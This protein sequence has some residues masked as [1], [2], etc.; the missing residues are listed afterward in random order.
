MRNVFRTSLALYLLISLGSTFANEVNTGADNAMQAGFTEIER[1]LIIKYMGGQTDKPAKSGIVYNNA[2]LQKKKEQG[3]PPGLAEKK[4]LPPGLAAQLQNNGTLPPGL[5]KRN[6]PADLD[7]QLPPVRAGHER[8]VL[9][10]LTIVLVE[11]ATQRIVDIIFDAVSETDT[12]TW[13]GKND[14]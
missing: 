4:A 14:R 8:S 10:D 9:D 1:Q 11:T 5:A 2:S 7:R 3:L 12:N 6:L 13:Q